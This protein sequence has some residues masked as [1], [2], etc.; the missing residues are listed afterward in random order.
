ML[1]RELEGLGALSPRVVPGGV[2]MRGHRRF[3]YRANL[4]SGL[5]THVLV[6]V[7]SVVADR[8]EELE[9][10]LAELPW[11]TVLTP[12]IGRRVSAS[13]TKSRLHHT[14]ALEERALAAIARRLGDDRREPDPEG[15]PVALRLVRDRAT[16]SVDTSGA[17]LHRRGYRLAVSAAPLREDLARALVVAS[18]WDP[19][20]P[21]VDPFC[22]A[23][24]LAIEAA[25]LARKLAP[26]RHRSFAFERTPLFHAPTW[27]DVRTKAEAAASAHA[28]APLIA[29]DRDPRA[30]E[31]AGANAA[32]AGVASDL[33]L[34][35]SA[36][37]ELD[38]SAVADS[39]KGLVI[40]NPP[41]GQRL[42]DVDALAP[43]YRA[44]GRRARELP[45]GWTVA[46]L[47]SERR[48]GMLVSPRLQTAFVTT[49]GGLKVR[50]LI[51]PAS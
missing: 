37:S 30:I 31:A 28:S 35:V 38:L 29:G 9:R 14:G 22:G 23:G 44:L 33:A 32:R 51:G 36:V 47:T 42:G 48:L 40:A 13:A 27:E 16:L 4:E 34:H 19:S 2:E 46:V 11:E 21:L 49:S 39:P 41:Y 5:A 15:V 6:R 25:C 10:A 8:F 24:T 18:G 20:T 12:G 26:G 17:P 43:L 50:A 45:A 1:A 3:I 7:G